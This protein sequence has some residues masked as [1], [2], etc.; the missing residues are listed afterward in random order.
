[1]KEAARRL[2]RRSMEAKTHPSAAGIVL[3]VGFLLVIGLVMVFS[4]SGLRAKEL[5]GDEFHYLI[6]QGIGAGIGMVLAFITLKTDP[7]KWAKFGTPF[8]ALAILMLIAVLIPGIGTEANGARRWFRIAGLSFQPSEFAKL[9][10]ILVMAR[11]LSSMA[12]DERLESWTGGFLPA[13]LVPAPA[14]ALI[15]IQPDLGTTVVVGLVVFGMLFVAGA[16]LLHLASLG[17]AG[18]AGVAAM[19]VFTPWRMQRVT[20]FLRPWENS[21]D[22]GFQLV[23]SLIA[24]AKGGVTGVGLGDSRQKLHFLPE[25]HTDFIFS[26]LA[27]EAGFIGVILVVVLFLWLILSGIRVANRADNRFEMLIAAG[28]SILIAAEAFFNLAVVMGLAPTKGLPLPFF[29]VGASS[30]IVHFWLIGM[31]LAVAR[32]TSA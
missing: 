10:V 28:V 31:L 26:V 13:L 14:L 16:R 18:M 5:Y 12:Q 29:S 17:L 15:L 11:G 7:S 20:A 30:L 32:R 27:E 8:Y 9:A 4:A 6:R 22:S 25:A 24:F 3:P 21:K 1:M 2:V 23:Q 19:I